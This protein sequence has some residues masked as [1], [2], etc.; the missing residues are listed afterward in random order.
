M[1]DG[2]AQNMTNLIRGYW[3]PSVERMG[4]LTIDYEY[5]IGTGKWNN[6]ED[7]SSTSNLAARNVLDWTYL[8]SPSF[9]NDTVSLTNGVTYYINVRARRS[10][11]GDIKDISAVG[12]SDGILVDTVP[13][14][15]PVLSGPIITNTTTPRWDWAPGGG[16]GI[17]IYRFK[18]NDT[19]LEV[20]ATITTSRFY[21]AEP[22][23][24]EGVYIFYVQE[25]DLANN[26]SQTASWTTEVDITP[27]VLMDFYPTNNSTNVDGHVQLDLY[28]S[29]NVVKGHPASK[30]YI[31]R[32]TNAAPVEIISITNPIVQT[33][34]NVVT[35]ARTNNLPSFTELFIIASNHC[36]RD[37]AGNYFA[38]I[39]DSNQ[40]H[41]TTADTEPP[42]VL[43][44][45]PSNNAT[46]V[47][48]NAILQMTFNE[49]LIKGTNGYIMIKYATDGSLFELIPIWTTNVVVNSN[50][51]TIYKTNLFGSRTTYY[52]EITHTCFSDTRNNWY[53]GISSGTV[54]RFT[55][56]DTVP[57]SI[58]KLFPT[59]NATDVS[60]TIDLV[61]TFDEPVAKGLFGSVFLI[62]A[63]DDSVFEEISI[64]SSKITI[65]GSNVT[66]NPAG[67]F[68]SLNQYYVNYDETCF[69][70]LSGNFADSMLGKTNWLFRIRDTNAPQVESFSPPPG[71]VNVP[72]NTT[73]TIA[74]N[75][76]IEKGKTGSITFKRRSNNVTFRTISISDNSISINYNL[77]EIRPVFN[78]EPGMA[79]YVTIG[80]TCFRDYSSNY[81]EGISSSSVWYFATAGGA[82][83]D[84]V[85]GVSATD[86]I[87]TDRIEI[88]WNTFPNAKN[89]E[90]W[91]NIVN[92]TGTATKVDTI[93]V[94]SYVDR[95]VVAGQTYY[96][97]VKAITLLGTNKFSAPDTGWMR[98]VF[99][100]NPASPADYDGDRLADFI[101]Y[102]TNNAYW[103]VLLS[104]AN[105]QSFVSF[106]LGYS[107]TIPAIADYDGD[108]LL[109]PAFY[110]PEDGRF[111]GW[112]SSQQYY[113]AYTYV[114]GQSYIPAPADFDG[115]GKV[116][117][118]VYLMSE[119]RWRGRLSTLDYNLV[120]AIIG[121]DGW[122]PVPQDFDGDGKADPGL[123]NDA[124]GKWKGFLSAFNYGYVEATFG[125]NGRIPLPCDIDGD[126]KADP[127]LYLDGSAEWS[128]MLSSYNYVTVKANLGESAANQTPLVGD[129]DGDSLFDLVLYQPTNGV[130]KVFLSANGYKQLSITF[131]GPEYQPIKPHP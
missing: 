64:S 65:S 58:Y 72:T 57:P 23:L 78:F 68:A 22:P 110:R 116:D 126:R 108:K 122:V 74:F 6:D 120:Y 12:S 24:V 73:L 38:G 131:G 60:P 98:A 21:I 100:Y 67:T 7:D 13:P 36:I 94:N 127:L 52:V 17:G 129:C 29:E 113:P 101:I 16:D 26:W 93:A 111:E 115:D 51:V 96:Y 79:Y 121:G 105:Y 125:G 19:N 10:L 46:G 112:L 119:G 50:Q 80:S 83:T 99:P 25:R 92:I 41:F 32:Y 14:N 28:F 85:T 9:T 31:R 59:N 70:D 44:Y 118:V 66:I 33:S 43:T 45:T 3:N 103:V 95:G 40:W 53:P 106:I 4:Y 114:G 97:W 47:V 87:F 104:S 1:D 91:R 48:G 102:E 123:Y 88:V 8:D 128:A 11:F 124:L 76:P 90:L 71:A 82:A 86:G 27:P 81:Y 37:H 84:V 42:Y 18:I 35:I 63:E 15:M 130:W 56:K 117:P 69:Q 30:L 107:N 20:G 5:C 89:Y 61:L 39:L 62:N 34:S 55:S 77:V 54:W 109:D 2:P 49:E 75:K